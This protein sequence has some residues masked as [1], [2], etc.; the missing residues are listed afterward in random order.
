MLQHLRTVGCLLTFSSTY[1]ASPRVKFPEKCLCE[2]MWEYSRNIHSARAGVLMT[3][4]KSI[5]PPCSGLIIMFCLLHALPRRHRMI[6][7]FSSLCEHAWLRPSPA[8]LVIRERKT[9]FSGDHV[10]H[11][12]NWI[13][14]LSYKLFHSPHFPLRWNTSSHTRFHLEEPETECVCLTVLTVLVHI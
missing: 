1:P 9:K 4:N 13:H 5:S 14:C 11:P 2:P 3:V 12:E 7:E 10:S 6:L 8:A